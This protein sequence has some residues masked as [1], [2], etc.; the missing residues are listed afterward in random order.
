MSTRFCGYSSC[1]GRQRD[2]DSA[3]VVIGREDV[4]GDGLDLACPR[5]KLDLLAKSPHAPLERERDRALALVEAAEAE[6]IDHVLA[7][8]LAFAVARQLEDAASGGENAPG[9]VASDEP[10]VR[11]R[12]V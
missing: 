5:T 4:R 1:A 2:E 6:R 11:G 3:V 12:V 10:R 7:H 9:P 8:Q